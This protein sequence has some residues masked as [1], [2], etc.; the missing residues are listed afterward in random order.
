VLLKTIVD[1]FFHL[2]EH[3]PTAPPI[4]VV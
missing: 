2:R 4:S 3:S 1:L